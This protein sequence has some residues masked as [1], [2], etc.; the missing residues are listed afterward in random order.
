MIAF[1]KWRFRVI[2]SLFVLMGIS[3]MMEIVSFAADGETGDY[4]WIP[5]DILNIMTG[6][7]IFVIFV[8]KKKV[9]K[10]LKQRWVL[11]DKIERRVTRGQHVTITRRATQE[12]STSGMSKSMPNT[13]DSFPNKRNIRH[14]Q[15][16]NFGDSTQVD[17]ADERPDSRLTGKLWWPQ[18]EGYTR[19]FV[20]SQCVFFPFFFKSSSFVI[21]SS[22]PFFSCLLPILYFNTILGFKSLKST[23]MSAHF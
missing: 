19:Q 20:I 8:C 3:W 15:S 16:T 21:L 12:T 22:C 9:W 1:W 13:I 5:T 10:L 23:E 11:L 18:C 6:V 17:S 2:F 4:I 7:Y 14:T